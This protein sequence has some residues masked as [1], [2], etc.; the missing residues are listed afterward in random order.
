Q[1]VDADRTRAVELPVSGAEGAPLRDRLAH[2]RKL[3]HDEQ[4][5]G[6]D[7]A[8]GVSLDLCSEER[9][10]VTDARR[11]PDREEGAGIRELLEAGGLGIGDEDVAAVVDRHPR[12]TEKLAVATTGGSPL[13]QESMCGGRRSRRLRRALTACGQR[14]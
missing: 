4:A 8:A 13:E 10:A 9:V 11:V 1:A 14:E 6:V 5:A 7:I 12:R 2:V 3:P